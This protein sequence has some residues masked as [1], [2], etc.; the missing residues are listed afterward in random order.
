MK[1]APNVRQ[2]QLYRRAQL[3]QLF[4]AYKLSDLDGAPARDLLL[5][6]ALLDLARKAQS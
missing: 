1:A 4:P 6:A 2:V 5:G 3:C